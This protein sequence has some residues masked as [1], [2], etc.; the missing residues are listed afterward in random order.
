[1]VHYLQLLNARHG[2]LCRSRAGP[3]S[4]CCDAR[5][6]IAALRLARSTA[7]G[8]PPD[9]IEHSAQAPALAA[10]DQ[11]GPGHECTH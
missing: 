6:S 7:G 2:L 9:G 3:I 4:M 10:P 11:G 8:R 5:C 1:M